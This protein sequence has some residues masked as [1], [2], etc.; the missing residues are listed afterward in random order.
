MPDHLAIEMHSLRTHVQYGHLLNYLVTVSNPTPSSITDVNLTTSLP[1]ELDV[2]VATWVCINATDEGVTCTPSGNGALSDTN[3]RIPAGGSV[4][5]VLSAPVRLQTVLEHVDSTA[6]VTSVVDPGPFTATSSIPIVIYRDSFEP[7]GDGS[8]AYSIDAVESTFASTKILVLQVSEA[9][10][11]GIDILLD[12]S[13]NDRSG[14]RVERL[15]SQGG[16]FLRLVARDSDGSE[17]TSAWIQA[18]AGESGTLAL[19][20]SD[21]TRIVLFEI[22]AGST[23][24]S[25]QSSSTLTYRVRSDA[26]TVEILGL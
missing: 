5:W 23:E 14:F 2:S 3:V 6:T 4:T 8:G 26:G 13:A 21:S 24:L 7:Y 16:P 15:T 9:A 1:V 22:E 18:R 10:G 20:D 11:Q 17:R 25:L 12:A 19:V